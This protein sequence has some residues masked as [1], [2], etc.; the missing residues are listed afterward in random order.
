M[1]EIIDLLCILI[2]YARY[3]LWYNSIISTLCYVICIAIYQHTCIYITSAI[4][5]LYVCR[6][7]ETAANPFQPPPLS[8]HR[9]WHYTPT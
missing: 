9:H 3:E 2:H 4:N 1:L 5:P 8:K 7:G 6:L